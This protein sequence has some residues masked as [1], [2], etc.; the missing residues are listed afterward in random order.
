MME[1]GKGQFPKRIQD[2]PAC[3]TRNLQSMHGFPQITEEGSRGLPEFGSL[4]AM[5]MTGPH[6]ER[7]DGSAELPEV[8]ELQLLLLCG[9]THTVME[10]A[11]RTWYP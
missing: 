9:L 1:G 4:I 3:T 2:L 8:K 7:P 6:N 5:G 11:N 10:M